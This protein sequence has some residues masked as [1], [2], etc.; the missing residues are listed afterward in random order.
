MFTASHPSHGL[1]EGAAALCLAQ[2]LNPPNNIAKLLLLNLN[3]GL[4]QVGGLEAFVQ[5]LFSQLK[6]GGEVGV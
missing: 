5:L 2:R 4:K 3:L 1:V 6:E